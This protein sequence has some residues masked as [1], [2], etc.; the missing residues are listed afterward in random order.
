MRLGAISALLSTA[1]TQG[2]AGAG[3]PETYEDLQRRNYQSP[4]GS[5]GRYWAAPA[6]ERAAHSQQ[7]AAAECPRNMPTVN[8]GCDSNSYTAPCEYPTPICCCNAMPRL[9]NPLCGTVTVKCVDF[10]WKQTLQATPHCAKFNCKQA[11]S[12]LEG[13]QGKSGAS[14]VGFG[15]EANGAGEPEG[16]RAKKAAKEG[17]NR[18]DAL[19]DDL[20]QSS[21]SSPILAAEVAED[22]DD[23]A[24]KGKA[25]SKQQ[26]GKSANEASKSPKPAPQGVLPPLAASLDVP[27]LGS[28]S[29]LPS[30][31]SPASVVFTSTLGAS[32]RSANTPAQATKSTVH[33]ST[34]SSLPAA[35]V[36]V[37][38][39]VSAA[40][41]IVLPL[42]DNLAAS[43]V[44]T[45]LSSTSTSLAPLS[46]T[47][48]TSTTPPPTSAS[49]S[50]SSANK[51]HRHSTSTTTSTSTPPSTQQLIQFLTSA[52]SARP[53]SIPEPTTSTTTAEPT[54]TSTTTT[55]PTTTTT[56]TTPIP[57]TTT[58][59]TTTTP[60]TTTTSTT[61]PTKTTTTTTPTTTTT[62]TTSPTTT[63]TT[64]TPTSTTSSTT[65]PT[66]TTTTQPSTSTASASVSTTTS[67]SS[68]TSHHRHSTTDTPQPS[69]AAAST[70]TT[71]TTPTT[72]TTTKP[73]TTSTTPTAAAAS[74]TS[75][76]TT[77]TTTTTTQP[78]TSTA[79]A[80]VSTTTSSSSHTS[81]H[82]HSTT[83]TPQPTAAA[84][85]TT[86][87]TTTPTTTTTTKPAT[88]STTTT[89]TQPTTTTT[90]TT[91]TTTT[92]TTPTTTTTTTTRPTTTT[93]T[94][95]PTTTITTKPTT[96]TTTTPTT[97]STTSTTTT[98]PT[99]TSTTTTT[100]PTTTSTTST[101]TTT[102]PTTT[103][104]TT[105]TT[106]T[107]TTPTTATT[108]KPAT[109]TTTTTPT[110]TTTTTS[111]T[112]AATAAA[113]LVSSTAA[114]AV[115]RT[116]DNQVCVFPFTYDGVEYKGCTNQ[117]YDQPWCFTAVLDG[118]KQWGACRTGCPMAASNE[119]PQVTPP[120][121]STAAPMKLPDDFQV[122]TGE[123]DGGDGPAACLTNEGPRP[124]QPCRFPFKYL[125]V[126]YD[127]CTLTESPKLWCATS[128]LASGELDGDEWGFCGACETGAGKVAADSETP[129]TGAPDSELYAL[130]KQH[131]SCA[132]QVAKLAMDVTTPTAC[133]QAILED[134][135]CGRTPYFMLSSS[136]PAWGC[137]CCT[138]PDGESSDY[139]D[140]YVLD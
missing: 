24:R 36:P 137:R 133:A 32:S 140:V 135:N 56:T 26:K 121:V 107:T 58:T 115:C 21:G 91:P 129:T 109:T 96:T 28:K 76:T 126:V 67:S 57:P 37:P 62:S 130:Y 5:T 55:M 97:T 84:E 138:D 44:L 39:G 59:T 65:T 38:P 127:E 3:F 51:H 119:E 22:L 72:T 110:P 101:T 82:R 136:F 94:T 132:T 81:H 64:T 93:T 6:T 80:S 52:A 27:F 131:T 45:A 25:A 14:L 134:D 15:D 61:S 79:S 85:S 105:T 29:N 86:T 33:S 7:Q 118:V 50:I 122:Q 48:T 99:T 92:T 53:A 35:N 95:T 13:Q 87:T 42:A 106:T 125:G 49:T 113:A 11:V 78:S 34:S 9:G 100:T 12:H 46:T 70:T 120:K 89:T 117:D 10:S 68:H 2:S 60:T 63:T 102:K 116:V 103:S 69:A 18:P 1:W 71:T 123:D 90:T 54:T 73:A 23:D 16:K 139:W 88:T 104:T 98:R 41:A 40:G 8:T 83:D 128:V 74:T 20:D 17:K 66:T 108:T 124:G 114:A 19:A 4:M 75:S 112:K 31:P 77:P 47:T 43:P 30:Q 111:T